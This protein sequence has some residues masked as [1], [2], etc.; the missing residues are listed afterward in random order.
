MKRYYSY[1]VKK[2]ISVQNLVTIEYMHFNSLFCYPE[3]VHDFSEFIYVEQGNIL[4]KTDTTINLSQGNFYLI[5][6][7]T[8]HS[9]FVNENKS[10]TVF[11][12]CFKCKS[13]LLNI[14]NQKIP[15]NRECKSLIEQIF[16]EAK[17]SFKFP[18]EKKLIP[19]PSAEFGAQ[20]LVE[21]YIEELL[22]I[23]IRQALHKEKDIKLFQSNTEL[24]LNL[25]SDVITML[26]DNVFSDLTLTEISKKIYYSKTFLNNIFKKHTN[27]TIIQ[28]YISLKIAQA[29]ILLKQGE[30]VTKVSETLRFDTPN[31]FSKVF[32]KHTGISPTEYKGAHRQT[33]KK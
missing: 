22:L 12:V 4:C 16:S 18:F 7:K 9:Y 5:Q 23:L 14:F 33:T 3:E 31:Y 2:N 10:A 30:S 27:N 19:L 20:Q 26:Q 32:K 11:I 17:K 15:L 6:E 1:S 8:P 13:D 29:K 24:E 25:I 28:Y 21:N